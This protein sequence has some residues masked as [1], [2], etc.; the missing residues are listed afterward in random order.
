MY[1]PILFVLT[2]R[3]NIG[4]RLDLVVQGAFGSMKPVMIETDCVSVIS[5]TKM[6]VDTSLTPMRTILSEPVRKWLK[7]LLMLNDARPIKR[8]NVL[9][10]GTCACRVMPFEAVQMDAS[11]RLSLDPVQQP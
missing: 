4:T 9:S 11:Y 2:T 6:Y 5:V 10:I 7:S 8:S 1:V 3:R